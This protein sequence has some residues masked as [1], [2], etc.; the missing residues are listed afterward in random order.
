MRN[1]GHFE[2]ADLRVT[3]LGA[4]SDFFINVMGLEEISRDENATYLGC[5]YDNNVD[6]TL[7]KGGTG[8]QRFT[9]RTGDGD[10]LDWATHRLSDAG[11]EHELLT[12]AAPGQTNSLRFTLPEGHDME[13]VT[14]QDNRYREAYR[15]QPARHGVT[16]IDGDH[17]NLSS[18]DRRAL[19][20]FM[21]DVLGA[22]VSDL[23]VDEESGEWLNCWIRTSHVHHDVAAF[24]LRA[25]GQ[26]LH[27]YAFE[28]ASLEHMAAAL[29]AIAAAGHKIE[30]GVSRHPVGANFYAY[31]WTPGGNRIE[32]SC[33][34]SEVP[35]AAEP[36]VWR[37]L[38]DTLDAWADPIIPGTF[39]EGS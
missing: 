29:D 23:I 37:G 17:I 27:H 3:D 6:L 14:V 4:A 32:L 12:D 35:A 26:S 10:D 9:L 16:P 36:R 39:T 25:K 8:V 13:L 30:L 34:G 19:G 22:R 2:Q 24:P 21:C 31:M 18:S 15:Q 11:V 1:I 38:Q 28:Y 33:G 5:G 20:Q 7:V